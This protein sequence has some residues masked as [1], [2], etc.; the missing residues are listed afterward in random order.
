VSLAVEKFRDMSGDEPDWRFITDNLVMNTSPHPSLSPSLFVGSQFVRPYTKEKGERKSGTPWGGQAWDMTTITKTYFNW[1]TATYRKGFSYLLPG[2]EPW[3]IAF[4]LRPRVVDVEHRYCLR[5]GFQN[6]DQ[7]RWEV[8]TNGI[9]WGLWTD[10]G[11]YRVLAPTIQTAGQWHVV[12]CTTVEAQPRR[13]MRLLSMDGTYSDPIQTFGRGIEGG[14]NSVTMGDN[15]KADNA[16]QGVLAEVILV[17]GEWT[18]RQFFEW[19][20]NPYGWANNYNHR[21]LTYPISCMHG[22]SKVRVTVDGEPHLYPTVSGDVAVAPAVS[23]YET[24]SPS[25]SARGASVRS[26]VSGTAR[27]CGED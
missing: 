5:L 22:E 24:L 6:G 2:H 11:N 13:K 4:M 14:L 15:L 17:K 1:V 20:S 9:Y 21:A 23:S 16:Y 25:V 26:A 3:T 7:Y 10:P 19:A 27:F 8:H 18:D 12:A